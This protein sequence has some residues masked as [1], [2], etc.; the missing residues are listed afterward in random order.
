M[1]SHWYDLWYGVGMSVQ[2]TVRIPDRLAKY[3]DDRV[4]AGEAA[5]RAEVITRALDELMRRDEREY[6]MNLVDELN[7]KG[8]SLYPD[9]EALAEWGAGQP[10][11][12]E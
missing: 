9:L 2:M 8:E 6:E 3:V 11:G 12:V 7:A 5:S 10:M 1:V 4:A